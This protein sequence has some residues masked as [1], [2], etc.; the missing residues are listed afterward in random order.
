[1]NVQ[2][3][4]AE[5]LVKSA[6]ATTSVQT[7]AI[8]LDKLSTAD[9]T[10]MC[11]VSSY[12]DTLGW[13][14]FQEGDLPAAERFIGAAW[15]LCERTAIGDHLGQ[16]YEKQGRKAEAIIQ[17]E[18]ALTKLGAFPE[19]RPRLAAL[20]PPG[21]D[22]DAKIS[23][24]KIKRAA[25]AGIKFK[26]SGNVDGNGEV[27]LV[28]KPGPTVDAVKFITG[29]D[30]LRATAADIRSV[31]F[32]NTFPD[33]TEIKLLRRAW[34]TCSNYTHECVVGLIPADSVVS[35]N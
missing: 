33:S 17:Y 25:E 18:L 28:F 8:D 10:R 13:I 21:T 30:E 27:W 34:V 22:L 26:N 6:I 32:P 16:I 12:W 14:K 5:T 29:S 3:D 31:K 1:M 4:R 20:L 11:S 7:L 19:T 35:V 15:G 24:A 9:T 2:M 23:A